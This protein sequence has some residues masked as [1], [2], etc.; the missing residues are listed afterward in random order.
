MTYGKIDYT[1]ILEGFLTSFSAKNEETKNIYA[2]I[3]KYAL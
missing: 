2:Y 1:A 3:Q